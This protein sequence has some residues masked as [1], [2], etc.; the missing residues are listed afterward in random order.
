MKTPKPVTIDFETV[1]I[2]ERPDYPPIPVGVSIKYPG[3]KSK[4]WAWGHITGNNCSYG[5]AKSELLKAYAHK[6]G[7]LCQNGKFDMDVAEA[8][9]DMPRLPWH[10]VHDTMF[11][12]YLDDPHQSQLGLKESAQRILGLAPDEQD[13]V[14]DWLLATQPV[15]G[16]KISISKQSDHYFG[17]Y[18]FLAPGQIVGKYAEG[19]TDRTEGLFQ[20]LYPSILEREMFIPYERE[21]KLS[22]ILLNMERKGV[23]VDLPRLKSDVAMYS[24]R[25]E[26]INAWIKKRIKAPDDINLDSGAQLVKAMIDSG[27]A[28]EEL[29]PLTKTGKY[30]TNKAALFDGVV[31]K[32]LLAVLNYRTQLSTCLNTFM[33]SWLR[34]AVKSN[35]LIYTTWNQIKSSE[36]AGAVGTRTGRLSST[37]NFQNIPQEFKPL[38][39]HEEKDPKKAKLL[40]VCPFKNLPPLPMVRSYIVPFKGHVLIDRDYSQQEPRILA[41]FDGGDLL[42]QYVA[43]PWM[44]MHDSAKDELAKMGKFYD[45]KPVKNTNLG[46]IY[47]MGVAKL[48]ERNDMPVNE[49]KVLKNAILELYPGLKAMFKDMKTRAKNNQPIRTWGGREYYC[50]PPKIVDGRLK[51]FDYKMVNILV[52]GSAAD[53]TKEAIIR[54]YDKIVELKKEDS[55]FILLNVHDQI[56]VSVPV[57]ECKQSMEIL[58]AM[59]ESIEFDVLMKSEGSVSTTNWSELKD[60]DKKG[61]ML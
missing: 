54:F 58:R 40:P 15:P 25:L 43:D 28:D 2:V 22:H 18:L 24:K 20:K 53:C 5:Q 19:D 44:D 41:H 27:C 39:R 42:E 47:G 59:M 11:L 33:K 1:G 32:V 10:L 51:T 37:P 13:E 4:Y 23:P 56:T 52:Q 36:G 6:D 21:R 3:K 57:K 49:S 14:K 7:V 38:F 46:L 50:E 29:I 12:L 45:R 8:H 48:A 9:M 35:G 26:E 60:Y 17:T 16:V 34:V 61:V 55:W 30:Q 31:D